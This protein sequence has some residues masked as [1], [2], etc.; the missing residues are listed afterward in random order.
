MFHQDQVIPR[1]F[2]EIGSYN[3]GIAAA[4][5]KAIPFR[6]LA[7]PSDIANGVAFLAQRKQIM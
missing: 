3:E 6:R 5:E 2:E 7:Q 1:Y 4:L